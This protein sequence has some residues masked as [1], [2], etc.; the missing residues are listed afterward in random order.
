MAQRADTW[1]IAEEIAAKNL[2]RCAGPRLKWRLQGLVVR[3]K[4]IDALILGSLL[5]VVKG[6]GHGDLVREMLP[7]RFGGQIFVY[8]CGGKVQD[9]HGSVYQVR[10]LWQGLGSQCR[11]MARRPP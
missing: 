1:P 11:T 7:D 5:H 9:V 8:Q 4:A 10:I 3:R 6:L 2:Q